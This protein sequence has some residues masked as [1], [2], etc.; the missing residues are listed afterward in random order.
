ML[1]RMAAPTLFQLTQIPQPLMER[2]Q[3]GIIERPGRLLPIAATNGTV[4]PPSSNEMAAAT[5]CSRTPSSS[6]MHRLIG[7]IDPE[8]WLDGSGTA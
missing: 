1:S 8:L 7:F 3:L 2:T 6:A 4:A 5:C